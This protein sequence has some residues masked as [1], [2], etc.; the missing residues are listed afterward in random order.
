MNHETDSQQSGS[1]QTDSQQTG[2]QQTSSGQADSRRTRDDDRSLVVVIGAGAIGTSIACRLIREH[3]RVL[4]VDPLAPGNGTSFGNAGHISTESIFPLAS[5]ATIRDVPKL[6]FGKNAPLHLRREYF[7]QI[8]PWLLRFAWAS[9]PSRFRA[10]VKAMQSLL[11]RARDAMEEL[12][13]DE[14]LAELLHTRGHM[15][16]AESKR[17]W[18][19]LENRRRLLEGHGIESIWLDTEDTMARAPFLREDFTGALLFPNS[20]HIGDPHGLCARLHERFADAGGESLRSRIHSIE[21]LDAGGFVLTGR[22]GKVAARKLVL[23][24]GAWSAPLARQLGLVMPLETERGYHLTAT[25][26]GSISG[27]PVESQDRKTIMTPM[28][29]GLRITG[30]VE[31]GGLDL[32]GNPQRWAE[33]RRH[34]G[35]LAPAVQ[36]ESFREWMGFRPSLPDHLPVI[37]EAPVNPD[38][39]CAFGHQHLGLTLSAV[40]AEI[41]ADLAAGRKTPI[42]LTPFRPDRF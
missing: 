27:V 26:V 7:W 39:I 42:D 23:A 30:F 17:S 12:C 25:G 1:Q 4:L 38:A 10:G 34:F 18:R 9:R 3:E 32:P 33:L 41:V 14:R 31:F 11:A 21:P 40:T 29:M 24:A 22:S 5:P 15:V 8:A 28:D 19:E 2:S 16:L 37:G 20:G 6:M 13:A 35:E 36:A